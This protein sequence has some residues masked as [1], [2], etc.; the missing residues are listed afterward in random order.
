MNDQDN[1]SQLNI[2]IKILDM[3]SN[4]KK[5]FGVQKNYPVG[6]IFIIKVLYKI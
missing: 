2:P 6:I 5:S 3:S 4:D 1:L